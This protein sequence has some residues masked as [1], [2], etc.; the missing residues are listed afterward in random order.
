MNPL[1]NV[2]SHAVNV[3]SCPFYAER[4]RQKEPLLT[5]LPNRPHSNSFV[6]PGGERSWKL[7]TAAHVFL[8]S[9]LLLSIFSHNS[10]EFVVGVIDIAC[11]TD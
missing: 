2:V 9:A 7:K 1:K 6:L 3:N 11:D 8:L 5:H 4:P 10:K